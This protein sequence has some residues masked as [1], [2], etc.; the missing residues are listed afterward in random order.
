VDPRITLPER[1]AGCSSGFKP[2][3]GERGQVFCSAC[4]HHYL[5]CG[6]CGRLVSQNDWND[7][8]SMCSPCWELTLMH[9]A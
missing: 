1:C 3:F 6:R 4:G 7:E 5:A 8:V 2:R 9:D